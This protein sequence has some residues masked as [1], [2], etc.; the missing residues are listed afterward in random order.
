MPSHNR[1]TL[2]K[3]HKESLRQ[4]ALE[5][6]AAR[7]AAGQLAPSGKPYAAPVEV[8]P[9]VVPVVPEVVVPVVVLPST[10][11]EVFLD[12]LRS[13]AGRNASDTRMSSDSVRFGAEL[14]DRL[15][16]AWQAG[17]MKGVQP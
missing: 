11:R 2:T 10:N 7:R 5:R 4:V 15:W 1:P 8:V 3:T 6:H 16:L 13:V 12:W 17:Q 14:E 9:V